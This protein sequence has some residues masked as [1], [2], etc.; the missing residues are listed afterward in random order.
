MFFDE[1]VIGSGLGALAVV[2][3]LSVHSR[4]LVIG[5]P[6]AGRF[7]YYGGTT[8]PCAFL[9]RAGLGSYWHGVIPIGTQQ[10]LTPAS[11]HFERLIHRFYPNTQISERVRNSWLFVPWRPIR[12][13]EE[14]QRLKA[15]RT[16]RLAFLHQM[17]SR[18]V[19]GD[20]DVSVHAAGSTYRARRL[21]VC[22]GALHTPALL[23]RSLDL[24]VSRQLMSDHVFCYLG[25][26]DRSRIRTPAPRVQRTRDGIWFESRHDDQ[27]K[28][29]YTL[30]PARFGFT[31]L[32]FGIERRN[33][34]G[35][36]TGNAVNRIVRGASLGQFAEALYNRSGLFPN[37]RTQSVYAQINVPDAHRFR[38][39]GA[40]LYPRNEVIQSCI[41]AARAGAPWPE[42]EPSK[43]PDIFIPSSHLYHSVDL[44]ALTR[45]GVNGPTS[46]VQVIDA[47]ALYDIG[48]DHHTFKVMAAAYQ[49]AHELA[50]LEH[51]PQAHFA[52]GFVPRLSS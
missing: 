50:Q 18:F 10:Y 5:G 47:S 1:I 46:R 25:R 35:L 8:Q 43:R 20:R 51:G 21:W 48:P 16:D 3:G 6:V 36:S 28:A 27:N 38:S 12:P 11:V 39:V 23:D 52:P 14:W 4:V 34:F 26:I 22:A 33:A 30:R 24:P 44:D 32:D 7:V 40:L 29:L 19:P 31:R 17:V 45:A 15:E 37:A 2:L 49:R 9:G 13:K 42:M 41:E